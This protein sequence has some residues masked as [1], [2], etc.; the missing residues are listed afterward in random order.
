MAD[1][2]VAKDL[3]LAAD[4]VESVLARLNPKTKTC[5]CCGVKVFEHFDEGKVVEQLGP[6]PERLRGAATRLSTSGSSSRR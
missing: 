5:E 2:S 1:N 6:V 4:L 3:R